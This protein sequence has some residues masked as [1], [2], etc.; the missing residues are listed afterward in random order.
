MRHHSFLHDSFICETWLIHMWDMT[1]SYRDMTHSYTRHH[2]F[3][4]ATRP[5]Y[6]RD[7]THSYVW[8]DSFISRHDSFVLRHDSFILRHASF[9]HEARLIYTCN[10]TNL[11]TR[12]DS[13]ISRHDSFIY[14]TWLI[15]I[16]TWLIHIKTWG[17]LVWRR[18]S[19]SALGIKG[20]VILRNP[21]HIH[22]IH[23]SLISRDPSHT[24]GVK[25]KGA[26]SVKRRSALGASVSRDLW[27]RGTLHTLPTYTSLWYQGT[28]HTLSVWREEGLSVWRE[29]GLSVPRCE[30][31]CDTE[32][33][34][35]HSQ[36]IS[37]VDT[38]GSFTHSRC[39]SVWR[40]GG[41]SVWRR[42]ALSASVSGRRVRSE[43]GKS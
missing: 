31:A 28:L 36:H 39:D 27:N 10:T 15:Y 40:E 38:K 11:Y 18:G 17:L 42:G 37:L 32:G 8:H 21:S 26:L 13:F 9:T 1:H 43:W 6:T 16:E 33:P 23:V 29:G 41:L 12:H 22:N 7:L 24:L 3:L 19:F 4:H 5:I 20:P 2:S 34:F 14:E 30:G 35:T 25:T